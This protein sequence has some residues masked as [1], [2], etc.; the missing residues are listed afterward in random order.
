MI[1]NYFVYFPPLA[2]FCSNLIT[3]FKSF[4]SSRYHSFF[5]RPKPDPETIT[6]QL[7]I[8]ILLSTGNFLE[9]YQL[10]YHKLEVDIKRK[11]GKTSNNKLIFRVT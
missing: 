6:I 11:T 8:E 4:I 10:V 7:L 2:K 9:T 3:V 5:T 1:L